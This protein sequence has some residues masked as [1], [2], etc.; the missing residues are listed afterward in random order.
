MHMCNDDES[1][2]LSLS[3]LLKLL[4]IVQAISWKWVVFTQRWYIHYKNNKAI[5]KTKNYLNIQQENIK[6]SFSE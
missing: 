2:F 6:L 3:C 4:I 5:L 1:I